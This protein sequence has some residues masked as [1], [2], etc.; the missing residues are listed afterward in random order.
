E[1]VP[2]AFPFL[3]RA[4]VFLYA[5]ARGSGMKIKILEAMAMGAPV[6]TTSEG[7]EGLPAE[8]GIHAGIS[9][10]DEGLVER[11]VTLLRD[12]AFQ[13][14]QRAAARELIEGWCGPQR[15]MSMIEDIYSR[16]LGD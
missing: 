3:R 14:R 1:N 8:D 10:S 11:T 5:P 13:N 6:V 4:G 12:G 16:M 2:D 9:E 7:V 15:T